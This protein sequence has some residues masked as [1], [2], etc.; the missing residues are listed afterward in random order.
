MAIV[1]HI[2]D[3]QTEDFEEQRQLV[4]VQRAVMFHVFNA[5]CQH[6]QRTVR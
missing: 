4:S 3:K 2:A 5:R 1:A 6:T